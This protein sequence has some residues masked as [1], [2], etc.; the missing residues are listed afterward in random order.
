MNELELKIVLLICFAVTLLSTVN[1]QDLVV[2]FGESC[3]IVG[4]KNHIMVFCETHYG[5]SCNVVDYVAFAASTDN[6]RIEPKTTFFYKNFE[7]L[8]K[9]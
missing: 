3:T 7:M 2:I 6:D 4:F 8:R 5:T 9:V 1:D